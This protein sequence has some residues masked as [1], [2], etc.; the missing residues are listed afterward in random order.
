MSESKKHITQEELQE[1]FE[2]REDGNLICKVNLKPRRKIGDVMGSNVGRYRAACIK[3]TRYYIHRLIFL[4]HNG[5]LPK[6]IDHI[7]RNPL[8]NRIENLRPATASQ[9]KRNRQSKK[10][11]T[12]NYVG[13]S[14][15]KPLSKWQAF[16]RQAGTDNKNLFLGYFIDEIEA[17]KAY[18]KAAIIQHKEFANLNIIKETV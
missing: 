3:G 9:N 1:L 4:Y 2:Y 18:N 13:V 10:N 5:W 16:I 14:W 11:S 12:S 6:E 8:D 17:A 15:C 7:N